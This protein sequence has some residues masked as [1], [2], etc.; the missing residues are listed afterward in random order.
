MVEKQRNICT[1]TIAKKLVLNLK[2]LGNTDAEFKS[3]VD[4]LSDGSSVNSLSDGR[5]SNGCI[6]I[7]DSDEFEFPR[8]RTASD[9]T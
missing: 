1:T 7:S 8:N 3:D 4:S 5:T 9:N 6:I 2:Y